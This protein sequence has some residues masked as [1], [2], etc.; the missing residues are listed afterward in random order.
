MG[1]NERADAYYGRVQDFL[2]RVGIHLIPKKILMCIFNSECYPNT[3]KTFVKKK[4]GIATRAHAYAHPKIWE[5]C[6]LE[7]YLL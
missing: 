4:D 2:Q 3:F 6:H 7:D 1:I 5:E